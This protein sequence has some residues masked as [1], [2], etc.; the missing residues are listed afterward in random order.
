VDALVL[1]LE[2]LQCTED[3]LKH[4]FNRL[5]IPQHADQK[6]TPNG[7]GHYTASSVHLISPFNAY[8]H[9]RTMP[10]RILAEFGWDFND[11]SQRRR[12]PDNM[13]F[14]YLTEPG[15][16]VS[17]G[18]APKISVP[19]DTRKAPAV[20]RKLKGFQGR[21]IEN[22][23]RMN[24]SMNSEDAYLAVPTDWGVRLI[25]MLTMLPK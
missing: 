5:R 9:C 23:N 20:E 10:I 14:L 6:K 19:E 15:K 25:P 11:R 21:I 4:T 3:D 24:I 2:K 12:T 16:R 13:R 18:Q 17:M 1:A 8:C 7:E 22:I